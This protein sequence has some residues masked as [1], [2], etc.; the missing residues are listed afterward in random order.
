MALFYF[1]CIPNI[2]GTS[3]QL[4]VLLSSHSNTIC[5]CAIS[6]DERMILK[7]MRSSDGV[8][9]LG[10]GQESH[11]GPSSKTAMLLQGSHAVNHEQRESRW[12]IKCWTRIGPA[13]TGNPRGRGNQ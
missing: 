11:R 10:L 4:T 8:A 13:R 3:L 12:I 2:S 9:Y 6:S 7:I 5:E 1:N